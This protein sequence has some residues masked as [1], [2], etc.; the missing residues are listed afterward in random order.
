MICLTGIDEV[1]RS[2]VTLT[3]ENYI[4]TIYRTCAEQQNRPAATGQLA[5]A[6]Q[7]SPAQ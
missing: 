5:G 4:K 1:C 3:I 7:V 6:F 2:V